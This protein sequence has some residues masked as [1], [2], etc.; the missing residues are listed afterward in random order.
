MKTEI[1]FVFPPGTWVAQDKRGT[2]LWHI[3]EPFAAGYGWKF[4]PRRTETGHVLVQPFL[5]DLERNDYWQDTKHQIQ[6]GET[7]WLQ[8]D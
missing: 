7:I 8:L 5:H 1:G 6:P 4:P 2:W 3:N